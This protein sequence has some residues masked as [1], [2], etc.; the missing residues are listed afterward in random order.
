MKKNSWKEQKLVNKTFPFNSAYEVVSELLFEK[1][2]EGLQEMLTK[3]C[4]D[5]V[6]EYF[7]YLEKSKLD[8]VGQLESIKDVQLSTILVRDPGEKMEKFIVVTYKTEEIGYL[9]NRETN[10]V[11]QGSDN[12]ATRT[13]HWIFESEDDSWKICSFFGKVDASE[14]K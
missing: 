5:S 6:C 8:L 11:V 1:N 4:Y 7:N 9:I 10:Q 13:H 12:V 2:L 14:F 3:E